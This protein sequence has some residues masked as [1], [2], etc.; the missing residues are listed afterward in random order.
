MDEARKIR[1]MERKSNSIT[2]YDIKTLT[3][4]CYGVVG[5]WGIV[6]KHLSDIANQTN[7]FFVLNINL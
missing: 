6:A 5:F 3:A 1:I 4:V 2:Y 7:L